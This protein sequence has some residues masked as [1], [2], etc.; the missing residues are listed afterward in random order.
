MTKDVPS[1][2][3]RSKQ[4]ILDHMESSLKQASIQIHNEVKGN[5]KVHNDQVQNDIST[6][7]TS[8]QQRNES[9]EKVLQGTKVEVGKQ[10]HEL[11]SMVEDIATMAKGLE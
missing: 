7:T 1:M 11:C 9:F 6:L 2:I 8:S 10:M 5:F 4:K 3:S